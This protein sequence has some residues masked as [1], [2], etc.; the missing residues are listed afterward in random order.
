MHNSARHSARV[1]AVLALSSCAAAWQAC[2]PTN[3]RLPGRCDRRGVASSLRDKVSM[4]G[5]TRRGSE[6][7]CEETEG[8]AEPT[9]TLVPL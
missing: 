7:G 3:G 5:A 4:G 8:V 6:R 2:L 1:L 9:V